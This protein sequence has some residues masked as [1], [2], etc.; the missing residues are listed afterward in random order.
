MLAVVGGSGLYRIDG[1]RVV[2]SIDLITPFGKPS[3]SIKVCQIDDRKFLFLPRHGENHELPPSKIN[4]RANVFAL[5]SLGATAV[6]SVSAVG[7]LQEEFEPGKLCFV[8]DFIDFTK[9]RERTFFDTCVVHWSPVPLVC[10]TLKDLGMRIVKQVGLLDRFVKTEHCVYICI[11]GPRFSTKA[12]SQ[13]FRSLG[14]HVIGMTACPECLLFKEAGIGYLNLAVITDYDCWK[15]HAVTVEEVM[16]RFA[17]SMELVQKFVT[18]FCVFFYDQE[19]SCPIRIDLD[20][21]HIGGERPEWF[22]TLKK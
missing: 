16:S 20:K 14:C 19:Y 7:S 9:F 15:D 12:E 22:E 8:S 4:F 3:S 1:V 5:K 6:L 2:D 17:A 21:C 13:M 10:P 18:S 11:E